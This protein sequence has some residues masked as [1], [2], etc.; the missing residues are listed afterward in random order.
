MCFVSFKIV[1]ET[2]VSFSDA[3]FR[4]KSLMFQ[5]NRAKIFDILKLISIFAPE[6]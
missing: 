4:E 6:N 1:A 3:K 5:K 2:E